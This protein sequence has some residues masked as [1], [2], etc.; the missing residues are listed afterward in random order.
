M[1]KKVENEKVPKAKGCV[2]I[3]GLVHTGTPGTTLISRRFPAE[4][5][6]QLGVIGILQDIII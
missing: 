5:K 4:T 1:T 6:E 2:T 3:P